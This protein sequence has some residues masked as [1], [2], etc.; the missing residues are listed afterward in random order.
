MFYVPDSDYKTAEQVEA[1]E[2][3]SNGYEQ[4]EYDLQS[5]IM[6]YWKRVNSQK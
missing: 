1:E 3:L 4:K 5:E 6:P 2:V